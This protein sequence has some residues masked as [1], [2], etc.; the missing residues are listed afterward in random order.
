MIWFNNP[1][2]PKI[3]ITLYTIKIDGNTNEN[4]VN[5]IKILLINIFFRLN[6]LSAKGKAKIQLI[7]DDKKACK[8]EK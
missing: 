1:F 8:N 7:N 6:K 4:P 3:P 5:D 2:V